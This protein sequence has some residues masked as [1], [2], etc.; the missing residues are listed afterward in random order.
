MVDGL[1]RQTENQ[2]PED[3][4]NMGHV[5][6]FKCFNINFKRSWHS[7]ICK[8]IFIS[9]FLPH[10]YIGIIIAQW[11]RPRKDKQIQTAVW[12]KLSAVFEKWSNN[13]YRREQYDNVLEAVTGLDS[14]PP[15][16]AEATGTCL[17]ATTT[18]PT[19]S[20]ATSTS[21]SC[22]TT[23]TTPDVSTKPNRS[24]RSCT[25]TSALIVDFTTKSS[26][27]SKSRFLEFF[28]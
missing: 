3:F 6:W 16:C 7:Q 26:F 18:N 1:R 11:A 23:T 21:T 5:L 10:F 17:A 27:S 4:Q 8:L 24:R 28:I 19:P 20:Y 12:T 22:A 14:E 13:S 25:C 15:W 9:W 2:T